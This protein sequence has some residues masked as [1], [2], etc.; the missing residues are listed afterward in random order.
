MLVSFHSRLKFV[1]INTADS[2]S[3]SIP[4]RRV[5][6]LHP[7][8]RRPTDDGTSEYRRDGFCSVVSEVLRKLLWIGGGHWY[9]WGGRSGCLRRKQAPKMS[10]I[11]VRDNPFPSHSN[12]CGEG[13]SSSPLG[14]VLRSLSPNMCWVTCLRLVIA[15]TGC[16][17]WGLRRQAWRFSLRLPALPF[18]SSVLQYREKEESGRAV[19]RTTSR[20]PASI[21]KEKATKRLSVASPRNSRRRD[22]RTRGEAVQDE[23]RYPQ[24]LP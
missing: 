3:H 16:D 2:T 1:S 6:A 4:S 11:T 17:A 22:A 9:P 23:P 10:A 8:Q 13:I 18:L 14:L 20:L 12:L 24:T 21:V 5:T 7:P 19:R 15:L